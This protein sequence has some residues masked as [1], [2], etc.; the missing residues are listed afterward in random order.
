M[1]CNLR[2][3]IKCFLSKMKSYNY[4]T[5]SRM[6]PFIEGKTLVN[7]IPSVSGT[8]CIYLPTLLR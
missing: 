5:D 8:C 1:I 2:L 7:R 3:I 4:V 6:V